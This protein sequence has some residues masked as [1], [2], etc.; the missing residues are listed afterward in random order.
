L[1]N[2]DK[3]LE[4]F[5]IEAIR[6][7]SKQTGT[8]EDIIR[9]WFEKNLITTSRTRGI[10]H[11][12]FNETG[13]IDNTVVER[14][15][16]KYLIRKEERSGAQ[17][18]E[19][20]HD[21]LIK[22]IVDSNKKWKDHR[23]REKEKTFARLLQK[24]LTLTARM[25]PS[26]L[27]E[28]ENEVLEAFYEAAIKESIQ[29]TGIDEGKL[30]DWCE[31]TL[32][33]SSETSGVDGIPN[34]VVNVLEQQYLIRKIEL[35][36][37]QRYEL[38]HDR[39]IKPIVDSNKKW[40]DERIRGEAL[41][42]AKAKIRKLKMMIVLVGAFVVATSVLSAALV[43]FSHNTAILPAYHTP[44]TLP[45]QF[46]V[47]VGSGPFGIAVDAYNINTVY[48][49]RP[50]SNIISIIE[51]KTKTADISVD[52]SPTGIA[53]NPK[54]NLTYVANRDF[55]TVSVIDVKT[56]TIVRYIQVD[57]SPSALAVNPLTNMVY[58]ANSDSNTTS[59]IDGKT[60]SV[61]K[62]VAVGYSP[63]G[64]AVNP[65]TN[66]VYVANSDSNTTSIIDGKTNSV[67]KAVAVGYSPRGVAVN[68]LTN[69]VYV[70]NSGSDTVSVID[71]KTN[72]VVK[73]VSVGHLPRGVAVDPLT[74]MVYVA[75]SG[76]NTVSVIDGR[77]NSVVRLMLTGYG[78][79][80][81]AF[82]ANTRYI[83]VANQ[84]DGTIYAAN[85]SKTN[86]NYEATYNSEITVGRSPNAL[87][88]NQGTKLLYVTNFRSNTVSVIDGKTNSVV[89]D[90]S[91][92]Y[93]PS[94]VAVNPLTTVYV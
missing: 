83:Y 16:K 36:G 91:V 63:R 46:V 33:A 55:N 22:P 49:T 59:I 71:G 7:V 42:G 34:E 43:P 79:T 70:A 23:E 88:F 31:K 86:L 50:Y 3:A 8:G 11:R 67:V 65:L 94:D 4:D 93:T 53:I 5:Y 44:A 39:L 29:K 90:V 66:M 68:P 19:L 52:G 75:N 10:V 30:R 54:T 64:V 73:D 78:P 47:D 74:N 92:G 28:N 26:S 69:M 32:I 48:V 81:V 45:P 18:Y 20:T 6:E 37:A 61:V 21:R 57:D 12:G 27:A 58:V 76:S 82:V 38:T 40:K 25:S 17:W 89:K 13:G 15:E 56:K 85:V 1:G 72:S 2:V 80:S 41:A 14:L 87:V 24:A 35:S 62:A 77:T 84:N 9:N 60:N 51:G